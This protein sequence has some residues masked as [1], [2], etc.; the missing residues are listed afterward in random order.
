MPN[1]LYQAAKKVQVNAHAP[2][3]QFKVGSAI[4]DEKGRVHIGC[5]VENAS[6]GATVCAERNAV[7][8]MTAAG[9]KSIREVM[10]LSESAWLP[11]GLCR[12]VLMEFSSKPDKVK[13]HIADKKG[14]KNTYI[15]SD[16]LPRAFRKNNLKSKTRR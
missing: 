9:G 8:A 4:L 2:Y 6:Y 10:V 13:I 12:Q 16:L 3:S 1:K 14:V 15:L 5:N 11:C 7:S